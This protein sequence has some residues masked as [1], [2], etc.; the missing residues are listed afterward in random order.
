MLQ[1]SYTIHVCLW[2]CLDQIPLEDLMHLQTGT[3]YV[4]KLADNCYCGGNPEKLIEVLLASTY[5]HPKQ[6]PSTLHHYNRRYVFPLAFI[7]SDCSLNLQPLDLA[8]EL[9]LFIQELTKYR[10]VL[11]PAF[12]TVQ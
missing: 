7:N 11:F 5:S 12:C 10:L 1:H 6:Y 8:K 2:V 4:S 3:G 9:R